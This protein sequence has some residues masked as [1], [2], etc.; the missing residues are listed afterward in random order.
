[1][2]AINNKIAKLSLNMLKD[3]AVKLNDDF[4]DGADIVQN[5]V[6]DRLMAIMPETEFV[7]F[8]NV[9]EG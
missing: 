9:L 3:M 2:E 1:M 4:R 8:C 5:A 7:E 6:M